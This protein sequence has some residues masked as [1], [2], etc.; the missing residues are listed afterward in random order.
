MILTINDFHGEANIPGLFPSVGTVSTANIVLQQQVEEYIKK[1][2]PRFLKR[3][4]VEKLR[5]LTPSSNE[6][7]DE[8]LDDGNEINSE[9]KEKIKFSLSHYVAYHFFRKESQKNTPIGNIIAQGE[10]GQR[11]DISRLLV[12]LWNQ[13]VENNIEIYDEMINCKHPDT[14]IFKNI[15]VFN[16]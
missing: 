7:S 10:N 14:E 3:F 5:S 15:N 11:T 4:F 16:F 12:L 6:D 1:Y 8:G 9:I 13:M 2:E